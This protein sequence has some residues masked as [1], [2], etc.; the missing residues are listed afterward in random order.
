MTQ[1]DNL[2]HL[3]ILLIGEVLKIIN[4]VYVALDTHAINF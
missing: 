3:D 2:G 4:C 1:I